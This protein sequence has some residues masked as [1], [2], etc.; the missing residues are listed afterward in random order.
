MSIP[1][2]FK[3]T[4]VAAPNFVFHQ[5]K[6]GLRETRVI[7]NFL[8]ASCKSAAYRTSTQ[9]KKMSVGAHYFSNKPGSLESACAMLLTGET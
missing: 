2:I 9:D 4:H 3:Q 1:K 5:R 6:V 8:Q 7:P